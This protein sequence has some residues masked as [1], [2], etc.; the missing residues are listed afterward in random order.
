MPIVPQSGVVSSDRGD[1]DNVVT[2]RVAL[3]SCPITGGC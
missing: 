3:E 2:K 1:Q